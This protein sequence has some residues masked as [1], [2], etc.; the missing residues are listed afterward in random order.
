MNV[1]DFAMQMERDG[2][3]YY[4][5]LSEK[6]DNRGLRNI[7]VMLAD[8]EIAHY[9]LFRN[10]REGAP[11]QTSETTILDDVKN[12][13]AEMKAEGSFQA[14][15]S[16]DDLYRKSLEIEKKS[17]DFYLAQAEETPEEARKEVFRKVAEEEEKHYR[18]VENILDFI[19]R[20]EQWL[21]DAEWYHLDEY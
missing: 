3:R 19:S 6:T 1:F 14:D 12:I 2:E 7:L 8:A 18:I 5:E 17:R 9:H 20:P 11:V 16:Q 15:P 21:E 4:R 13:F 10:M